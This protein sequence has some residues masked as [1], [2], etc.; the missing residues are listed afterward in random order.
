MK[1]K[2]IILA[3]MLFMVL[4]LFF[5]SMYLLQADDSQ[6]LIDTYVKNG[7]TTN[8]SGTEVVMDLKVDTSSA[9]Q[10]FNNVTLTVEVPGPN[11][12]S[13]TASD[14]PGQLSKTITANPDG[15]Y[16]IEWQLGTLS[17]GT[18]V[19]VPYVVKYKSYYTPE[20]QTNTITATVTEES[21]DN[22]SDQVTLISS[23]NNPYGYN[24]YEDTWGG[25]IDGGNANPG[26]PTT[27]D[28]S[29]PKD[30]TF[31]TYP[32]ADYWLIGTGAI[33]VQTITVTDTLPPFAVFDPVKNPGWIDN[34]DGT[35]S[36]I[37]NN[38]Q[39][40]GPNYPYT[41]LVRPQLVLTFPGATVSSPILGDTW[42]TNT[43]ETKM[44]WLKADGSTGSYTDS[45]SNNFRFKDSNYIPPDGNFNIAKYPDEGWGRIFIDSLGDKSSVKSFEI[46]LQ[47]N[48]TLRSVNNI[49]VTDTDLHSFLKYVRLEFSTTFT[50]VP[51]TYWDDSGNSYNDTIASTASAY[52]FPT[53]KN[54][55][56]FELSINGSNT[57]QPNSSVL[58]NTFVTFIDP[59]NT[60]PVIS[61]GDYQVLDNKVKA[62]FS[63]DQSSDV[64]T[65][66]DNAAYRF[67]P[68]APYAYNTKTASR[69]N[70]FYNV[71]F[72]YSLRMYLPSGPEYNSWWNLG[73]HLPAD[74][75]MNLK[76]VV[77]LLP[78]GVEYISGTAA[79]PSEYSTASW[80]EKLVSIEPSVI[81]NYNGTGRTAL[82]W[83]FNASLY[84]SD[85]SLYNNYITH[86]FAMDYQVKFNL[87]A[88]AYTPS[89]NEVFYDIDNST[90]E[91]DTI[92]A[93]GNS[94][95]DSYD[96]NG[97][98]NVAE[99]ILGANIQNQALLPLIVIP[100]KSVKGDFDLGYT[101]YPGIG[102]SK[103]DGTG[104][105]NLSVLN[106]ALT[107][108]NKLTIIDVLPFVG[109]KNLVSAQDGSYPARDTEFPV[110]LSGPITV[111]SGFTVYYTSTAPIDG[112]AAYDAIAAWET[113][114]LDYS[115]VRAF[116]IVMDN[117]VTIPTQE[118][119]LYSF[120]VDTPNDYSTAEKIAWNSF[121]LSI[122]G[123]MTYNEP[124][125]VGLEITAYQLEGT[126][127]FD[128][129][130]DGNYDAG[131][132]AIPGVLVELLDQNDQILKTTT[133]DA[134]GYYIFNID[135]P[136]QYKVRMTTPEGLTITNY[137]PIVFDETV[138]SLQASPDGSKGTSD[139][140][141]LSVSD[142]DAV[143]NGGFYNY[144]AS[145]HGV[146]W[147][148]AN[149][150]G[151][152]D[153]GETLIGNAQVKL[154]DGTGTEI[155][156]ITTDPLGNY[157]FNDLAPGDYQVEFPIY[158]DYGYTLQNA[159]SNDTLDS[160]ADPTTRKVTGI[161][162]AQDEHK[163]NIDAGVYKVIGSIGGVYWLDENKDGQRQDG[164][165][166][167]QGLTV[168][169][170]DG[171]GNVIS[172]ISTGIDGSYLFEDLTPGNYQVEFVVS[173]TGDVITLQ[174]TGADETDSDADRTTKIV[175]G[176]VLAEGEDKVN[177]DAG[178]Y[179]VLGSISGI[180]WFDENYDN[181]RQVTESAIPGGTVNLLNGSG[182]VIATTTTAADGSYLFDNLMP[183]DYKVQFI[184]ID[185]NKDYTAEN[186][187]S[188]DSI[189]SDAI[190]ST[191]ITD[192]IT[193]GEDED[194]YNVDA[195]L[196]SVLGS[197]SGVYWFD[198]NKDGQRQDGET[199]VQG[200]TVN[201]LD[202]SGAVIATTTTAADGS[203][204][205]DNLYPGNYQIE[206]LVT[207]RGDVLTLQNIGAESTDSDADRTSKIVTGIVLEPHEAEVDIDA[208]YYNV[209]GSIHGVYWDDINKDGLRQNTE[210]LI[211]G[212]TVNLLD[213]SDALISSTT[214]APD[215]SYDFNDLL[216]GDYKVV[217]INNDITKE[218]TEDNIGTD[219]AI[220]SDGV[221]LTGITGIIT[222]G[223]D[224]DKYNVD[225]GVVSI[226][227][228]ISGVYWF[229]ENKD[230][231][232]QDGET[233]VQGLTVNLLDGSGAVIES[234]TTAADGSYS[235]EGLMPGNYQIEFLVTVRGDVLT[236]ENTGADETDS[237][238]DRT[239]KIV[240][241]IV[242]DKGENEVN[243]DAGYYNVLGSIHGVYWDDI[244]KDGIRQDI[245]PLIS[246][247]VVNLL[248]GTGNVIATTIT[249]VDG[250]YDFE[251]LMPGDYRVQF[252]NPD[253]TRDYVLADV[254]IDD[255][256]D[257]DAIPTTGITAII[258]LGE[259]EDIYNVDVGIEIIL[260]SIHG[261]YWNDVNNDGLRDETEPVLGNVTVHLL[262]EDGNIISTTLTLA[263]GSYD[264]EDLMPGNYSVRFT[265]TDETIYQFTHQNAGADDTIDSD[266]N[267]VDSKTAI[268]TLG[269]GQHEYNVDA[270]VKVIGM[271]ALK[272]VKTVDKSE[273]KPGDTVYYTIEVI[274]TGNVDLFNL[275]LTDNLLGIKDFPLGDLKVGESKKFTYIEIGTLAY[276]IPDD[277]T[278]EL[279]NIASVSAETDF[280]VVIIGETTQIADN[281]T[282]TIVVNKVSAMPQTGQI[283]F[284]LAGLGI[285]L[286]GFILVNIARVKGRK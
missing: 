50:N 125:K 210:A 208:G 104:L 215:G 283:I 62:T 94:L 70:E 1:K 178:Y 257:S 284:V 130:K 95:T 162:L 48:S 30:V 138:S 161:T 123:G 23:V 13:V 201:L 256:I 45:S 58:I 54:I 57:I 174:N 134:N 171:S 272:V 148:D 51:I 87:G 172:T 2:K 160:D 217:F 90:T 84:G 209:L 264:F 121:G 261:V 204:L 141:T 98:G 15:S 280:G 93:P 211:G 151:I 42:Y 192:T 163:Y 66:E 225:I 76:K 234:T 212:K 152:R 59:V 11:L 274:N 200:L 113:S 81:Y 119:R 34:G 92:A 4:S 146:F 263:D 177:V 231:Q 103:V 286:N 133:T 196:Y 88:S 226:L 249:A 63:Y 14:L 202:G 101:T 266:V 248:D 67:Y 122:D 147:I 96:T 43:I 155:R 235:F 241:G 68:I 80:D 285:L 44:E 52:I 131:E 150:D 197:I 17:A 219:D 25:Y 132:S 41:Y 60:H 28:P 262:D 179:N 100:E 198:E 7:V 18:T 99:Q 165:T 267:P 221:K 53:D 6:I 213:N 281:S 239:T 230:G 108:I 140:A 120:G 9:T 24:K 106:N 238:A 29:A 33:D 214:T 164:E 246:G 279:R 223:E 110:T 74:Q 185:I 277:F 129:D 61:V 157:S 142:K 182:A 236:L 242:L 16:T 37:I 218:F 144:Y 139:I 173:G 31:K 228:S 186:F 184:N 203:Y 65:V 71:P 86:Y 169:L 128:T 127:F 158:P 232:R 137:Q 233:L 207:A 247:R 229:D 20:G 252:M 189:D 259:D 250:S 19:V 115:Q 175:S 111:P 260:G 105:Y 73:H 167:V 12:E 107:P 271:P 75:A 245:E 251:D 258:T 243:V 276:K 170:L 82:I 38:V 191:G 193:L 187:G 112:L 49:T 97:N 143:R 224:E 89:T 227:G 188:D 117:G 126:S 183:G 79:I 168:N 109:D 254:G 39:D 190:Q 64:N 176:L 156:T 195:G 145:L 46:W 153:N 273:A 124:N 85:G 36:Y 159:G 40:Q 180:Y 56:D 91:H 199:L 118:S 154:L 255:T 194:K 78:K 116:K 275:L 55:V 69:V 47:N 269:K 135:L 136:G 253:V 26:S 220:D 216:P 270:G 35:V 22:R 222:L 206:F 3:S 166:L 149:H 237:D 27:I 32:K 5:S 240:T 205:F 21:G 278:G 10:S 102:H 181:L 244:N 8:L 114:P 268:I 282:A 77:D 83:N 265:I 72:T